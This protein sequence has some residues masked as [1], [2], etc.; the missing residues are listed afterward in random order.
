MQRSEAGFAFRRLLATEK[1]GGFLG[2][3]GRRLSKLVITPARE[4]AVKGL[5]REWPRIVAFRASCGPTLRGANSHA[6]AHFP[7]PLHR[8]GATHTLQQLTFQGQRETPG[9]W[10]WPWPLGR[11]L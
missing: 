1:V 6:V 9:G 7:T 2:L 8:D 10:D 3:Y 4:T 5:E 11:A